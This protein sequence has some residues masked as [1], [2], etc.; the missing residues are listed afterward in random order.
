METISEPLLPPS[1]SRVSMHTGVPF[2]SLIVSAQALCRYS[3]TPNS[4]YPPNKHLQVPVEE[5]E[6]NICCANGLQL[7]VKELQPLEMNSGGKETK[8]E[9]GTKT[10]GCSLWGLMK[11]KR[12]RRWGFID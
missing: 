4:R 1:T 5:E 10:G 3:S 12:R 2:H 11:G 7:R 6:A 9:E 8:D